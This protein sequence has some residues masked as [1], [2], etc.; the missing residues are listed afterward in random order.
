MLGTLGS[1]ASAAW[2]EQRGLDARQTPHWYVEI[3]LAARHASDEVAF[4]LNIYPEEWGYVLRAGSRV[5]SIR[6]T[7]VVF[8]HGK[9]DYSV[10]VLITLALVVGGYAAAEVLHVSAPIG[11]VVAGLVIGNKGRLAMS[12]MTKTHVDL[13]WK[14]IDEILNAVLFLMIGLALMLV[15]CR[16][17]S[18]G[19]PRSRFP[20]CSEGAGSPLLHRCRRFRRSGA[21]SRTR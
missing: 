21:R 13:F 4:E 1:R 17:K 20:S 6:V 15:R 2:L 5:S 14:L 19:L 8:V 9:D 12:D 18:R 3:T 7:D 10:E 11:A 16:G